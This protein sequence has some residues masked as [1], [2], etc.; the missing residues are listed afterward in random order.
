MAVLLPSARL[1]MQQTPFPLPGGRTMPACS[2]YHMA[3]APSLLLNTAPL[4]WGGVERPRTPRFASFPLFL[5]PFSFCGHQEI[6]KQKRPS[7]LPSTTAATT[8]SFYCSS[9]DLVSGGQALRW[10]KRVGVGFCL[11]GASRTCLETTHRCLCA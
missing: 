2:P 11:P 6:E 8:A 1:I 9:E 5:S 3:Q 7:H 10:W 4:G